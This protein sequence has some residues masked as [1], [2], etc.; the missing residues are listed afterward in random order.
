MSF[1][2]HC[3]I[4]VY[5][6]QSFVACG[7]KNLNIT[8]KFHRL[9]VD[10]LKRYKSLF[11][12][13]FS[14]KKKKIL[15]FIDRRIHYKI[16]LQSDRIYQILWASCVH[17]CKRNAQVH[18]TSNNVYTSAIDF[19]NSSS[20]LPAVVIKKIIKKRLSIRYCWFFFFL[21]QIIIIRSNGK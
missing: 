3:W 16:K 19:L 20:I 11:F 8:H 14:K 13:L 2:S 9:L 10:I 4:V 15:R 12:K 21:S 6:M 5:L 7:F 18:R 17:F 1:F